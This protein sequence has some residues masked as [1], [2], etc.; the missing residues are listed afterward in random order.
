MEL[1]IATGEIDRIATRRRRLISQRREELDLG[2]GTAPG[3]ELA[4]IGKGKSSIAGHRDALSQ[5][6]ERAGRAGGW[7]EARRP[8]EIE[9]RIDGEARFD[10][11]SQT[12]EEGLEIGML[13]RLD[14]A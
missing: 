8:R 13:H 4:G 6:K 1:G 10:A 14:E 12:V 7:R 3:I 9:Q 2:P 11:I 5:G